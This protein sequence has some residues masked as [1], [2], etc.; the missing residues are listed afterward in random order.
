M[1]ETWRD[2]ARDSLPDIQKAKVLCAKSPARTHG[3]VSSVN[4]LTWAGLSSSLFILF[5]L[6][7]STRLMKFIGNSRKMIKIWD[8]FS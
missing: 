6:S 3:R 4:G 2:S 7:F 5:L 1:L 8:Q